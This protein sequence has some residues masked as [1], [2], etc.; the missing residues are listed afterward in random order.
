MPRAA[1]RD[2][3][4]GCRAAKG[5]G[6]KIRSRRSSQV[7]ILAPA[8]GTGSRTR[9]D[10]GPRKHRLLPFGRGSLRQHSTPRNPRLDLHPI[11]SWSVRRSGQACGASLSPRI[12]RSR[13]TSSIRSDGT[14][15]RCSSADIT[16]YKP[17]SGACSI[18]AKVPRAPSAALRAKGEPPGPS[19]SAPRRTRSRHSCLPRR[20]AH[21]LVSVRP[22]L[23]PFE[24]RARAEAQVLDRGT[25]KAARTG[26]SRASLWIDRLVDSGSLGSLSTPR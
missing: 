13:R 24:D 7:R 3:C 4:R 26:E 9:E 2:R 14:T 5:G 8:A 23:R 20:S 1:P 12:G 22:P 16:G 19:S 6:L 18:T 21:R 11:V 15:L 10:S 25:G 17:G